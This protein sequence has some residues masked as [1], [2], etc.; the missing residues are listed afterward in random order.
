MLDREF[1]LRDLSANDLPRHLRIEIHDR[2]RG[3]AV[4][5]PFEDVFAS[6][7][8]LRERNERS[9]RVMRASMARAEETSL[10]VA[11]ASR[12]EVRRR[13]NLSIAIRV[14]VVSSHP[15][16]VGCFRSLQPA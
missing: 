12:R 7:I 3:A 11:S 16:G 10:T 13:R 6:A 8:G 14:V 15:N 1:E 2:L 4:R 9:S 5:S